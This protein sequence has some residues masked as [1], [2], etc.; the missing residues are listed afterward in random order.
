MTRILIAHQESGTR[1][2]VSRKI[3]GLEGFQIVEKVRKAEDFFEK[4]NKADPDVVVLGMKFEKLSGLD[5]LEKLKRTDPRPVLALASDDVEREEAVRALSYGAVDVLEPDYRPDEVRSLLEVSLKADEIVSGREVVSGSAEC[6]GDEAA[7]FI[8]SST[9]GPG[10]LEFILKNFPDRLDAPLF[11]A[12]HMS[13]SYT[14]LFSE[15]MDKLSE[16]EV[17][18]AED[19]EEV[20]EG[21]VY[22]AP[23]DCDMRVVEEDDEKMIKLSEPSDTT[24]PSIDVLF[25]SAAEVYGDKA[26]G[27]VLTGMGKD[28][29][30]GSRFIRSE[31]G[32]VFVQNRATSKIYGM[33]KHVV[34]QGDAD[35]I[36]PLEKIPEEMARCL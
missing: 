18:E 3:R 5:L 14:A 34:N 10:T 7:V 15:R 25:R 2:T 30:I 33:P 8:G 29:A 16:F 22:F 28:G 23:G 24:S 4:V 17:K 35:R 26:L 6:S 27:V 21:M 12:Q 36:L 1:D 32:K 11:V 31:G 9:G 20:R 19:G 13:A